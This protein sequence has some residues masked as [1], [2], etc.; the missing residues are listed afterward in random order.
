MS[1]LKKAEN[2]IAYGKIGI[3]GDAG[4]GKTRTA[5]EIAI[6]LHKQIKSKKPIVMFDTEPGAAFIKPIFDREG[7][8]LLVVSGS[9]SLKDC[10]TFIKEA[11]EV[12]DIAI[13]D[14]VTHIWR[15][16]QKAFLDRKNDVRRKNGWKPQFSIQFE[17]WAQI[18]DEWHRFTDSYLFSHVHMIICGRASQKYEYQ[19]N[20]Q[21]KM[22]LITNGTKMS[23][24][25]EMGYEPSL[26]I[27]M[28]KEPTEDKRSHI[29]IAYV[30]K[31]RAD[32][33]NAQSFRMPTFESFKPHFDFINI[34]G[35]HAE[36][37][38]SN[39]Q[40]LFEDTDE[41]EWSNDK[42]QREVWSEE[43]KGLMQKHYPSQSAVDKEEKLKL[44]EEVFSTRSWKKIESTNSKVLKAGY[45]KMKSILFERFKEEVV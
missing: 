25:K 24:E 12:S 6:G 44:I 37:S 34:G 42:N 8:E 7:I 19:K 11:E 41:G 16:V 22:E 20:D 32:L 28:V 43:I 15:E 4:S 21:G 27:E 29:N 38:D 13:I 18:K 10:M 40:D 1:L 26:L 39:S 23:T 14:S 2:N 35:N 33:L 5:A 9:R 3:Y 45:E 30:E 31:D 17:D 36:K